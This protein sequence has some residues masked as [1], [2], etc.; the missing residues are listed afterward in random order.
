MRGVAPRI[1]L[2]AHKAVLDAITG[3]DAS[4]AEELMRKLVTGAQHD[5]R[6]DLSQRHQQAS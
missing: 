3:R 1:A 6:R 5:I 4:R 2:P